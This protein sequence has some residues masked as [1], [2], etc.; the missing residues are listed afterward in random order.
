MVPDGGL[1]KVPLV[2]PMFVCATVIS[3]HTC[4]PLLGPIP[5]AG[6]V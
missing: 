6:M 5:T 4:L 1:H 3:G 2:H